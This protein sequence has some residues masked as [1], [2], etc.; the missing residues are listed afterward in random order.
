MAKDISKRTLWTAFLEPPT[1]ADI[2][3]AASQMKGGKAYLFKDDNGLMIMRNRRRLN[4][5]EKKHEIFVRAV[6]PIN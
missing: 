6:T 2:K 1:D 4:D 5:F 3:E